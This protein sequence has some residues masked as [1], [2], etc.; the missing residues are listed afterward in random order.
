MTPEISDGA[1]GLWWRDVV[2]NFQVLP[3]TKFPNGFDFGVEYTSICFDPPQYLAFLFHAFR[4]EGGKVV[5]AALPEDEGLKIALKEAQ[6]QVG[7]SMDVFVNAAGL[8]A[9]RLC[10]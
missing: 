4:S 2:S 7:G 10:Q 9:G 6:N 5:R 8:G 3:P 1:Q